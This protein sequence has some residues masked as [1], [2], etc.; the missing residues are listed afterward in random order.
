MINIDT[1]LQI[2]LDF[3]FK[4]CKKYWQSFKSISKLNLN[5]L[6]YKFTISRIGDGTWTCT[7]S[8]RA[9]LNHH[10]NH[11][12]QRATRKKKRRE[13]EWQRS[14]LHLRLVGIIWRPLMLSKEQRVRSPRW[15]KWWLRLLFVATCSNW[16][17][18]GSR[19]ISILRS[20]VQN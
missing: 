5:V 16:R 4:I 12:D 10:Y 17:G 9:S 3:V 2:L 20:S 6:L 13:K 1:F 18:T 8:V 14:P 11:L 15:M 7:S 19:L